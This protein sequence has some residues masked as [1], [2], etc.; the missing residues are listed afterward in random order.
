MAVAGI[1]VDSNGDH[2]T[3]L[4]GM[5]G[6]FKVIPRSL[7]LR[8][9]SYR[10]PCKQG[11][12]LIDYL[13]LVAPSKG[14]SFVIEEI[15]D[16]TK[17]ILKDV[18]FTAK[19]GQL[20][21]LLGSSGSGKTTMLDL[22]GMRQGPEVIVD[23]EIYIG[24]E[25]QSRELVKRVLGY[26]M[27][28]DYCLPHLTV[29]ETFSYV[30]QMR[31]P[32]DMQKDAAENVE[33]VISELGL[34][35]VADM[36]VGNDAVRGISGGE[37]RRVSVGIQLLMNP[38]ILVLDEPTSGLDSFTAQNVVEFLSNLAHSTQRTIIMSI[39]QPRSEVFSYIDRVMLLTHGKCAYFGPT[40]D[41]IPYFSKMGYECPE[42]ANPLDFYIDLIAINRK[43]EGLF[44]KSKKRVQDIVERYAS[45]AICL[46]VKREIAEELCED[47][48]RI[49][50]VDPT[51]AEGKSLCKVFCKS[52]GPA[53]SKRR[54]SPA[55]VRYVKPSGAYVFSVLTKRLIVNG[56]RDIPGTSSRLSQ[57]FSFGLILLLFV[58]IL[59]ND[60][61]SV[62]N[63]T[64]FLYEVLGGTMFTGLLVEVTMFPL[65]RD[66]F[67]RERRDGLYGPFTFIASYSMYTLPF[68]LIS[69][70]LFTFLLFFTVNLLVTFENFLIFVY[71]SFATMHAG[72]SIALFTLSIFRIVSRGSNVGS[73]ILSV[74]LVAST[75][76]LRAYENMPSVVQWAAYAM[77]PKYAS[78]LLVASQYED[79]QLTCASGEPCQYPNGLVYLD[80]TFP[81]SQNHYTRNIIV[82]A[83]FI[84]ALRILP[85]FVL[86]YRVRNLR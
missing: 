9:L 39:H 24:D 34:R 37:R 51:G 41:M 52:T 29:R 78:E 56:L 23:G 80:E 12:Q 3:V 47:N 79:L 57:A 31:L 86:K 59:G 1:D 16:N 53:E 22:I 27:Q 70:L 50:V 11:K 8:N 61:I 45:S 18:D 84:V 13:P 48:E 40:R 38:S 17:Y 21:A 73:L 10:V 46:D 42:L 83:V 62:Q 54:S 64:G 63:R 5:G 30:A 4:S 33:R 15:K 19:P 75:G 77:Q 26:V 20:V 76:L 7:S 72:E 60:Q 67:Y 14:N 55:N 44:L 49:S 66:M 35:H 28:D 2:A 25:P 43:S 81:G 58:G 68:S 6:S 69:S 71:V 36:R 82:T 32:K 74:L 65:D 85:V